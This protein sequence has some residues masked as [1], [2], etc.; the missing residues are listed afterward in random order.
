VI[1]WWKN[2]DLLVNFWWNTMHITMAPVTCHVQPT[3]TS[4]PEQRKTTSG[5]C[6]CPSKSPHMAGEE[7]APKQAALCSLTV[8][9]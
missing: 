9:P 3:Q 5:S 6:S 4:P 2:K 8:S 1:S 7:T